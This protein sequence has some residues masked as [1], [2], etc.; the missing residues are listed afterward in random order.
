M[1]PQIYENY[2]IDKS[3]FVIFLFAVFQVFMIYSRVYKSITCK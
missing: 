3:F 1:T 2:F